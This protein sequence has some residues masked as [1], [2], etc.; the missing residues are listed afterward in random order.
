M[1][2]CTELK[3]IK[4]NVLIKIM[5]SK[6]KL[7]GFRKIILLANLNNRYQIEQMKDVLDSYNKSFYYGNERKL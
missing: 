6:L 2:F 4:F 7:C 1:K 5:E 3:L